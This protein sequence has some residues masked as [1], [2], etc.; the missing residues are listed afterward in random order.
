MRLTLPEPFF[1]FLNASHNMTITYASTLS[2]FFLFEFLLHNHLMDI[3]QTPCPS[4][5]HTL[6]IFK[7]SNTFV[8]SL[9]PQAPPPLS[10]AGVQR[11]QGGRASEQLLQGRTREHH[12]K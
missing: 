10:Q 1:P 8:F 4:A 11:D 5:K 9:M 6:R 2:P 12:D 3:K 7:G